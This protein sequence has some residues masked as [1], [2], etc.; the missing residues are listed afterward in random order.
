MKYIKVI[1]ISGGYFA[2]EFEKSIKSRKPK[3][4][5]EVDEDTVAEQFLKGDAVIKII[6]EDLEREPI[7]IS[8]ESDEEIIKKYLGPKFLDY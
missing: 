4:V 2:R 3:K 5:R 7:E 6:F 8:K 1:R